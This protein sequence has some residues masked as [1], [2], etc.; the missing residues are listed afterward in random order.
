MRMMRRQ[1]FLWLLLL[2]GAFLPAAPRAATVFGPDNFPGVWTIATNAEGTVY[3]TET[4]I[5]RQGREVYCRVL[6]LEPLPPELAPVNPDAATEASIRRFIAAYR[7][8][9]IPY[10]SESTALKTGREKFNCLEFAE[11]LVKQATANGIPAQV[12]GIIFKGEWVGHA[13]AGFPTAEGRTLYF[14]STPGA[15]QI[16]HGAHEAQLEVGQPYRRAGGGELSVVGERP[17]TEIVPVTRLTKLAESLTED[18]GAGPAPGTWAVTRIQRVPAAGIDYASTNSLEISDDQLARWKA[19]AAAAL[20]AQSDREHMLSA[21]TQ[22]AAARAAAQALAE[23]KKMAAQNDAYGQLRMGE[24][25][26]KGDGVPK[27]PVLGRAYLRQA[28]DQESATAIE[29]LK[30]LDGETSKNSS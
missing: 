7:P 17:I 16:S 8:P 14:D 4:A 21:V 22:I 11:D 15:G 29:E 19:A 3:A 20:A 9:P 5:H 25:Y 6:N 26:L 13:V 18:N 24:R 2:G 28:A 12:I 10:T 27:N 23:D 1:I 30:R